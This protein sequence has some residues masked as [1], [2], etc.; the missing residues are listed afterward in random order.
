MVL[1]EFHFL[2]FLFIAR[3]RNYHLSYFVCFVL[4]HICLVT[5]NSYCRDVLP[6]GHVRWETFHPTSAGTGG[7]LF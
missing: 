2:Y 4:P 6:F 7:F 1:V 3:F 5:V